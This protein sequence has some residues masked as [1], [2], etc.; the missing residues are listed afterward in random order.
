[1]FKYED[2]VEKPADSVRELCEFIEIEFDE[3]M[4]APARKGSSFDQ[5]ETTGFDRDAVSRWK[6]QL[7]PWMRTWLAF[8]GG[9]SMK[10]FGYLR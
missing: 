8:W 10:E 7:K 9:R 3:R 4:L 6:T 2:L 5:T 1:L